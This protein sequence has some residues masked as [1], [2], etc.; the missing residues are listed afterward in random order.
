MTQPNFKLKFFKSLLNL[1]QQKKKSLKMTEYL[2]CCFYN[3]N[4]ERQQGKVSF[5][6]FFFN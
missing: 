5:Y 3:Y 4:E 1:E 6:F 2:F